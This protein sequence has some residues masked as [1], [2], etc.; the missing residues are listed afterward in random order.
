MPNV[1]EPITRTY[2]VAMT[3]CRV[4]IGSWGRLRVEGLEHVPSSGPV[5]MA[6]NHDSHWDPVAVGVAALKARQIRALAKAELWKYP[7]LGWIL[8]GMRQIKL[9]RGRGPQ[10]GLEDAIRE[11]R[12]GACIG[13]F[14]EGTLS[15][16]HE[17]RARSGLGVLAREV[18]EATVVNVAV[19]DTVAIVRFPRR[20][21]IT[22]RFFPPAG[23]QLQP[24]EEPSA[25]V[26]RLMA[27]I[28]A[29]VPWVAGG[30]DPDAQ[31]AAAAERAAA[32]AR[33]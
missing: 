5:L 12:A 6:V 18:P 9:H 10:G 13:I 1:R 11:L 22:V 14:P 23:G 24:G 29:E 3:I 20:P 17:L 26:V 2:R 27:E 25:F 4:V 33:G 19:V 8:D 7:G 32:K 16:G 15:W 31:H 30:R 28:R 21:R